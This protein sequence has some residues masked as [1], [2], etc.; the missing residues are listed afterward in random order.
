M[1]RE[2]AIYT[3]PKLR[4]L[5]SDDVARLEAKHGAPLSAVI[6]HGPKGSVVASSPTRSAPR[7]PA[8]SET[9]TDRS[10]K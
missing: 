3:R 1:S 2:R 8:S 6:E 4:L 10:S 9:G 5:S 7:L